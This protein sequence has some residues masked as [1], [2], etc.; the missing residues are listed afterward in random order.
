[1]CWDVGLAVELRGWRDGGGAG[2]EVGEGREGIG[3]EVGE[4]GG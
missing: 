1:V 4:A 3:G 2:V